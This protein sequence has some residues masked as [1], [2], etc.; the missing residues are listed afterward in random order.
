MIFSIFSIQVMP[1]DCE[2]NYHHT[3][4]AR[5]GIRCLYGNSRMEMQ[6]LIIL[7][8]PTMISGWRRKERIIVSVESRGIR[9]LLH[10]YAQQAPTQGV[11]SNFGLCHRTCITIPISIHL[12][13][14]AIR[15]ILRTTVAL[16]NRSDTLSFQSKLPGSASVSKARFPNS[17][18]GLGICIYLVPRISFCRRKRRIGLTD[19]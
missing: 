18:K 16:K 14:F 19:F 3:C 9:D 11:H 15:R 4:S 6:T 8:V 1:F 13:I 17:I 5:H 2:A 7:C 12:A 10:S